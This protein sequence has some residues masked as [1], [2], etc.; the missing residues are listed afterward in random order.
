MLNTRAPLHIMAV[1]ITNAHG[2]TWCWMVGLYKSAF[3][4]RYVTVTEF[5]IT[6]NSAVF[7][8]AD[9]A[10]DILRFR[11]DGLLW[12][13]FTR[14]AKQKNSYAENVSMPWR[15]CMCN[16]YC[17]HTDQ[18]T[19]SITETERS[20]GW[21]PWYSL[22]TLK[23]SFN[24]SSEYQGR[25]ADELSVSVMSIASRVIW[26]NLAPCGQQYVQHHISINIIKYRFHD[27][28]PQPALSKKQVCQCIHK[29]SKCH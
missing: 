5:Q 4:W 8:T 21:Q 18:H 2:S 24:V 25:Q 23:T 14:N 15:H 7:S 1:I 19:K 26:N 28:D 12:K 6:G 22:E 29:I 27:E 16:A 20:S 17:T 10:D 9:S 3:H 11:N 13:E